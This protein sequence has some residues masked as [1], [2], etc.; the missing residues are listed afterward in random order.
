MKGGFI[1]LSPRVILGPHR[2]TLLPELM[3]RAFR[4]VLVP[5]VVG[6]DAGPALFRPSGCLDHWFGCL[7]WGELSKPARLAALPY[8]CTRIAD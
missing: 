2:L 5:V 8:R 7:D 1:T 4:L 6:A 3:T